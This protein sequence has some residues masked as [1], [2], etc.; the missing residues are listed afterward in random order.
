MTLLIHAQ[1][2]GVEV[3]PE[4]VQS[5]LV[6][7]EAFANKAQTVVQEEELLYRLH[8]PGRATNPWWTRMKPQSRIQFRIDAALR[9][10]WNEA[11]ELSTMAVPKGFGLNAW[12]GSAAY[13]GGVHIGGANQLFIPNPPMEWITTVPFK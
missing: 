4:L 11:T 7:G 6:F 13:Q 10:E 2:R 3:E 1:R 5:V 9:P 12:E 8:S